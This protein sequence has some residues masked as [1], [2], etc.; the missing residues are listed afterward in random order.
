MNSGYLQ[1][2]T[3][4]VNLAI[5]EYKGLTERINNTV[6][7]ITSFLICLGGIVTAVAALFTAYCICM[8]KNDILDYV[9]FAINVVI[10]LFTFI[11]D[12]R[13]VFPL[14]ID[15][16]N[17]KRDE[18]TRLTDKIDKRKTEKEIVDGYIKSDDYGYL[19]HSAVKIK[20]LVYANKG[21]ENGKYND[22]YNNMIDNEVEMY[23]NASDNARKVLKIK[24]K[25]LKWSMMFT[26]ISIF[27]LAISV[28]VSVSF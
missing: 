24:R 14:Q 9:L 13:G 5:E 22:T 1:C 27:V 15:K 28:A 7:A 3:S 6:K 17:D 26:F 4:A 12:C 23:R 18:L 8:P 10:I 2:V 20:N 25:Q 19:I 21:E 11:I 16:C